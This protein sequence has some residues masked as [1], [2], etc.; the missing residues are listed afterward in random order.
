MF[1][2]RFL[3]V[4]PNTKSVQGSSCQSLDKNGLLRCT[5]T[6]EKRQLEFLLCQKSLSVFVSGKVVSVG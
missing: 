2:G 5:G 1:D 6:T 3:R 4:R